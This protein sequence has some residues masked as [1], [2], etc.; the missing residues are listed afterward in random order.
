MATLDSMPGPPKPEPS[1]SGQGKKVLVVGLLVAVLGLGA[2][3]ASG[4]HKA[5]F[6]AATGT[7]VVSLLKCDCW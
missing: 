7:L 2:V 1:A 5:V 4:A 3:L 6:Q